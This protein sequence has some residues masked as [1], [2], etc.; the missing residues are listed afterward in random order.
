MKTKTR[1]NGQEALKQNVTWRHDF[2][3]NKALYVVMIPALVYFI[4]MNYIPMF[5]IVMA[6]Q[7]FSVSKGFFG[8]KFIGLTNFIELFTG[9]TFLLALRNTACMAVLNLTVGFIMPIVFAFLITEIKTKKLKRTLQTFSYMPHFVAAVV[10]VQLV[11]EFI[12]NDGAITMLLSLIGLERQNWLAN[13]NIPVFWIINT[14]TDIWQNI[15]F[16]SIMYV[17]AI[18]AVSGD[19]HEAAVL[20]GAGRWTRLTKITLPCIV[21]TIV[22]LFTMKIGLVF[23]TGFDKVLLMYMPT[24]YVT[25]DVLSTYTYR[26]AFG[27]AA[28]Y[29]LSAASGLFQSVVATILLLIGNKLTKK[30]T[31]HSVF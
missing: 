4:T 21:P 20:D 13:S 22:M 19:Y 23:V 8:S 27:S 31:D 24:T 10:V 15:A 1:A 9:D 30:A 2:K 29:G 16:G 17:A 3:R 25:S 28:N 5:G 14:F 11:K 12:G 6:F 18:S 7:D 26:K